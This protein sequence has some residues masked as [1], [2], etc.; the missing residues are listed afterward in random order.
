MIQQIFLFLCKDKFQNETLLFLR[1]KRF[2][3]TIPIIHSQVVLWSGIYPGNFFFN[4][5]IPNSKKN[6]IFACRIL[7]SNINVTTVK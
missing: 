7:F 5:K 1:K 4:K 2:Q 6:C 3:S